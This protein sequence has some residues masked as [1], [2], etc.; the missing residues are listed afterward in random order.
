MSIAQYT[1]SYR[2]GI[3]LVDRQH[4]QLFE[5]VNELGRALSAG[6]GC[7]AVERHVAG[8]VRLAESHFKTERAILEPLGGPEFES[9]MTEHRMISNWLDWLHFQVRTGTLGVSDR[10]LEVLRT[11][12]K[13][14]VVE[15]DIPTFGNV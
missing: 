10:H 9:H 13:V 3:E 7:E 4:E 15:T 11:W 12:V 1:E 2:V 14:H 6:A 8:L 5:A